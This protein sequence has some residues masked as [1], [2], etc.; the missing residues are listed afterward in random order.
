MIQ[1]LCN[2][3]G[4][5]CLH[6]KSRG[7]CAEIL[8]AGDAF[9]RRHRWIEEK[10]AE[11]VKQCCC[12]QSEASSLLMPHYLTTSR[13]RQRADSFNG[14]ARVSKTSSRLWDILDHQQMR[15]RK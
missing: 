15:L 6:F 2:A 14:K 4:C 11:E 10:Y 13:H 7:K 12:V 9:V 8:S 3:A 1:K 5:R